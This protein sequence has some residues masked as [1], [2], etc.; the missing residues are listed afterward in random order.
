[1]RLLA[2]VSLAAAVLA[3]ML[4]LADTPGVDIS[5]SLFS[6]YGNYGGIT[7]GFRFDVTQTLEV[8]A[9]GHLFFGGDVIPRQVGLWDPNGNLLASTTVLASDPMVDGWSYHWL[10]GP[11]ILNPGVNYAVGGF[12]PSG[13]FTYY[14]FG[15]QSG[16]PVAP[17][18]S[19]DHHPY[20]HYT[21]SGLTD[22]VDP[23]GDNGLW[24]GADFLVNAVPETPPVVALGLGVGLLGILTRRRNR[25]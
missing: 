5:P 9:L 16:L 18:I 25:R 3:P 7:V 8:T 23:E 10:G 12:E 22:P 21:N 20:Y 14:T 24:N 11:I 6:P 15:N 2:R 19:T 13:V 17:G 4:A 1:M